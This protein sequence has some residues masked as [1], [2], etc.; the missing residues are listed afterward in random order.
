MGYN[1]SLKGEH[2][3][4]LAPEVVRAGCLPRCTRLELKKAR[5]LQTLSNSGFEQSVS[6]DLMQLIS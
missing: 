5:A 3:Q 2:S 1:R 4:E 6:V